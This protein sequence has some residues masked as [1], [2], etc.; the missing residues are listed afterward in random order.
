[1]FKN[2]SI[3][4]TGG[5]GSFGKKFIHTVLK[6]YN[7]KKLIIFSRDEYKQSEMEKNLS[8]Y[9]K[10]LRF[11]IGDVRDSERLD[12]AMRGVDFVVHA[13]ALKQVVAAE[14]NPSEFVKTNIL[15]AENV[16]KASIKNEVFKVI[17]LSTDKAVNPVNLYGATK[18]SSDKL[19]IAAN[20]IV[21]SQKTKF[22]V[23]R[24]GNVIGSRGS[25]LPFFL[26]LKNQAKNTLPITHKKMTRFWISLEQGVDFSIKC[27]QIMIGGE[28]LI[29]KSPTIKIV[30]LAKAINPNAKLKIIGIRP[31]EKIHE[32]LCSV[33]DAR[34][35]LEFNN[36]Y[37]IKPSIT[38]NVKSSYKKNKINELG[39]KVADNFEYNSG[40]NKNFLNQNQIKNIL[41]KLSY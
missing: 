15:G 22:S 27:F 30:D 34:Y 38:L 35:T 4:V 7:P 19:F 8:Q 29:A 14:Y 39:K 40:T 33:D 23:V 18:L 25:I 24:Y 13:A 1:M 10:L 21:G 37:L 17:A 16:I 6:K 28:I 2:K 3:L 11:F 26:D 36:H 9:N 12:F 20:N 32:S 41:K 5:T 31:G